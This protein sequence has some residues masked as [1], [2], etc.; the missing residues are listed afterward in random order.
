MIK[1][2]SDNGIRT[3]S[4][5]P[6]LM[7]FLESRKSL[8]T[9]DAERYPMYFNDESG[10]IE[11]AQDT[12]IVFKGSSTTQNLR[13]TL[14]SIADNKITLLHENIFN[15]S[16]PIKVN[17]NNIITTGINNIG[18]NAITWAAFSN[19]NTRKSE[20]FILRREISL[21]Y[22]LV[23]MDFTEGDITTGIKQLDYYD[24]L[25]KKFP[26]YDYNILKHILSFF[27][28]KGT[29]TCL[30]KDSFIMMLINNRREHLH[31]KLAKK[32]RILIRALFLNEN[33]VSKQKEIIRMS[34]KRELT[35]LFKNKK[36]PSS[37]I[38]TWVFEA[39]Q[40]I[41]SIIKN[42][43]NKSKQNKH[44][45]A[46]AKKF[47]DNQ[48]EK[49]LIC[50]STDLEMTIMGEYLSKNEINIHTEYEGDLVYFRLGKRNGVDL[51]AVRTQMGSGSVG[52]SAFTIDEAIR[53]I[54]PS[55]VIAVGIAFGINS[56]SQ[57]IGGILISRQVQ[58][59]ELQRVGKDNIVPRGDKTPA[60]PKLVARCDAA[61]LTWN[62]SKIQT[63]L[64]LSG[65]KLIDSSSFKANLLVNE[66]EAI[67]GEM[68][69]AGLVAA[70]SRR[71]TSWLIMKGICD[72]GENKGDSNQ[73]LA[74]SNT[75]D[76]F[77]H[78]LNKGGWA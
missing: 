49:V 12:S 9:H 10:T 74:C 46:I 16:K 18:S 69:A 28:P 24:T 63:G 30:L 6:F 52:G 64:I 77:F 71:N 53:K 44:A 13:E 32:I 58:S 34:I 1:L 20:E 14:E 47:E 68:E 51:Y 72:W 66:P 60:S 29:N 54:E 35:Q 45:L 73:H 5:H 75:F 50:V 70:C 25:S 56:E 78:I 76:L 19:Q 39:N 36:C 42:Y 7:D 4:H 57:K 17:I 61:K 43:K 8:Y 27:L 62:L 21:R 40:M 23:Y 33:P 67:G 48:M 38:K 15:Y 55:S 59:Y 22:T 31:R 2:V 37:E 3:I 11:N 26:S 41:D 65:D